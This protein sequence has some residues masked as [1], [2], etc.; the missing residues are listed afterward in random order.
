[1]IDDIKSNGKLTLGEDVAD[2]G[3]LLLAYMA[4]KSDTAGQTLEPIEG[5]TPEQRFFVGYGQSWCSNIRDEA[6]RMRATVD[7]HSLDQFRT[8]GVV[9]NMPEFQQAFHC[10]AGS[11]MVRQNACR[12]W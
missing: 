7:P 8:N 6:K 10:K 9:S 4:W 3:G 11:A 5:L 1:M 2:L 12:V